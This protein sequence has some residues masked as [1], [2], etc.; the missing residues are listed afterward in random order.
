MM[1]T[2]LL[3]K[4]LKR[5]LVNPV[6]PLLCVILLIALII[7]FGCT[8]DDP[9]FVVTNPSSRVQIV[10]SDGDIITIDPATRNLV[11]LDQDHFQIHKGN[12]FSTWYEQQVS[13]TGDETIIAFKT[14]DTT[15]WLQLIM[16]VSTSSSADAHIIE[17]PAIVDNTGAPLTV[18]NRDRNSATTS[19]IIDTS[20]N[21]DVT[22]Q[23][24]FFTEVTQGNVTGGTNIAHVHLQ[25]GAGPKAIGGD[26][27]G[28]EEWILKQ[29]TLY[30]FVIESLDMNDNVHLIE[31]DWYEYVN[32]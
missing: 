1:N 8:V 19:T 7:P 23:A 30:A 32:K 24:M 17:A 3:K 12:S 16:T 10:D 27:R 28:T 14:S 29:N 18:F 25:G 31:L 20:Q 13:D 4:K 6:K 15:K 11:V 5:F 2:I 26:A 21:P 9:G 22:G